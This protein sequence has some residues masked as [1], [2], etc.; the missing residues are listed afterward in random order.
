[1][2]E[3]WTASLSTDGWRVLGPVSGEAQVASGD[4]VLHAVQV[5]D[6][7]W[8]VDSGKRCG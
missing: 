3:G 7:T 4:V 1:L 8:F 2:P 5:E 6:G